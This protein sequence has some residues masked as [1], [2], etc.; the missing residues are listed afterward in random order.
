MQTYRRRLVIEDPKRV[1][2]TDLPFQ[3][4]QRVEVL[5]LEEEVDRDRRVEDLKRLLKDTQALSQVKSIT[6]QEIAAEIAAYRE[7]R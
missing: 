2:L 4:G 5:V 3:A 6:E 7:G 1:V